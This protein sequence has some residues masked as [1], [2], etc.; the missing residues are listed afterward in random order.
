MGVGRTDS[1]TGEFSGEAHDFLMEG[2]NKNAETMETNRMRAPRKTAS[3][4]NRHE[5]I[6][7][8]RGLGVTPK[9]VK[10]RPLIPKDFLAHNADMD[11]GTD[12]N[13]QRL[14]MENGELVTK[15][16]RKPKECA[17]VIE[18]S[19]CNM[20]LMEHYKRTKQLIVPESELVFCKCCK[21][22]F[23]FPLLGFYRVNIKK[24]K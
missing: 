16:K 1:D 13:E 19:A 8:L 7:G 18:W 10:N 9:E 12:R 11:D 2:L 23:I 3:T 4:G 15:S 5:V 21:S 17:D 20:R 6:S 24:V 22:L 14:V